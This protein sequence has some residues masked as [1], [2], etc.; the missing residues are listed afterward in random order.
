MPARTDTIF[1]LASV[2]KLFTAIALVQ[3]VEAGRIDLDRTV[4]SYIPAFAA[5]GKQ[6]VTVRQLLTHSVPGPWRVR[7]RH[8]GELTRPHRLR[9][10]PAAG[11]RCGAARRLVGVGQLTGVIF[12][13]VWS[14]QRRRRC[15]DP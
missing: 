1:D 9:R 15:V 10:L 4:A 8:P 13:H 12:L 7:R 5:N 11:R 14:R 3:Q 2:S 6:A